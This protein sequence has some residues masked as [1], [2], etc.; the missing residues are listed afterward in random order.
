MAVPTRLLHGPWVTV[1]DLPA[2]RPTLDAGVWE[3]LCWRASELLYQLSGRQWA[4][5]AEAT[6]VLEQP[7][8]GRGG[9]CWPVWRPT[10]GYPDGLRPARQ[11]GE[12][13]VVV[14]LP[15]P[16]C[17]S[18]EG[19]TIGGDP[20]TAWTAWLP[21]GHLERTDGRA[22]PLDG[23][24]AVRFRHGLAPPSGG[25]AAA[26]ELALEMGAQTVD[27]KCRLP[28]RT[29]SVQREGVTI[30]VVTDDELYRQQRTG[31]PNVDRWLMEVN[32]HRLAR[33]ATAWSPDRPRTRRVSTP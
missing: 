6:V 33:R 26:A 16:P 8:A 28:G 25:V 3:D 2:D 31:L 21:V 20:F 18:V 11:V 17:T 23:T 5:E 12:G 10:G 30:A 7:R 19:V 27:Q 32:P 13:H 9:N 24:V 22:W 29:T 14:A 1:D 15:D 4:T